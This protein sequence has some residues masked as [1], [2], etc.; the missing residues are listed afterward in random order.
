MVSGS[1]IICTSA[2]S[3]TAI[4]S[5][6]SAPNLVLRVWKAFSAVFASTSA[7]DTYLCPFSLT[8]ISPSTHSVS[9]CPLE[10][11]ITGN[12]SSLT[13]KEI[14]TFGLAEAVNAPRITIRIP[15]SE[16][17]FQ[18]EDLDTCVPPSSDISRNSPKCL[19][20]LAFYRVECITS[21]VSRGNLP[22][23]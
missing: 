22:P 11:G 15:M 23:L 5:T 10:T 9:V 20:E 13:A 18:I 2:T 7:S 1:L 4:N 19:P 17:R 16:A 6:T 8:R 3:L 21:N 14:G 12:G